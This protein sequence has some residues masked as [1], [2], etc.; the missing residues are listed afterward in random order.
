METNS[1]HLSFAKGALLIYLKRFK[2]RLKGS[3][4][5]YL[6]QLYGFMNALDIYCK[7]WLDGKKA[8]QL[9]RA[10]EIV[11]RCNADQINLRALDKCVE[12]FT[13]I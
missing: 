5:T 11:Q 3:N 8:D 12:V 13:L 1:S 7:E 9:L 4:A 2:S 10:S 6:K